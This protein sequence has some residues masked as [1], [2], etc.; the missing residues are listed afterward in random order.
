MK[1][2]APSLTMTIIRRDLLTGLRSW[3]SFILLLILIPHLS[4]ASLNNLP[5]SPG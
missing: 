3:K 1:E 2:R 4:L 5:A